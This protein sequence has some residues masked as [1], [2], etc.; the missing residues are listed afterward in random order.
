MDK[1]TYHLR[2]EFSNYEKAYL[3][4]YLQSYLNTVKRHKP[5]AILHTPS[6]TSHHDL[7][8]FDSS[9]QTQ[10]SAFQLFQLKINLIHSFNPSEIYFTAYLKDADQFP[11]SFNLI[12]QFQADDCVNTLLPLS[13]KNGKLQIPS[14]YPPHHTKL[15]ILHQLSLNLIFEKLQYS[16]S[17]YTVWKQVEVSAGNIHFPDTQSL[18]HSLPSV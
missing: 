7:L 18:L 2:V 11:N 1:S 14:I 6:M 15:I 4:E 10:I 5:L 8:M 12:N 13:T 17:P 9:P 16:Q 3:T